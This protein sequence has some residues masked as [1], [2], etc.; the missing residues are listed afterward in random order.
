M[1]REDTLKIF[2]SGREAWN[3]R[4]RKLLAQKAEL[5]PTASS[6]WIKWNVA[7]RVDFREHEFKEDVDFSGFI[8]PNNA[9][10]ITLVS[11]EPLHL[12]ERNSRKTHGLKTRSSLS[13]RLS[14]T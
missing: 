10:F 6:E 4:A 2:A 8:F 1:T 11:Q 12:I 13:R 14:T 7:A 9:S 5:D 3:T